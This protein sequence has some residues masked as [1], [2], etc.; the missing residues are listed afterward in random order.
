[1]TNHIGL[2]TM[3]RARS[4]KTRRQPQFPRPQEFALGQPFQSR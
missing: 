3:N 4:K 2:K 1:M